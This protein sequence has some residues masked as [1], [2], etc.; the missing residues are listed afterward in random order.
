MGHCHHW[1]VV[2]G[3]VGGCW[4]WAI[5]EDGGWCL[6]FVRWGAGVGAGVG[7]SSLLVGGGGGWCSPF[8]WGHG[9]WCSP[10]VGGHGGWCSSFIGGHRHS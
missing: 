4:R 2:L 8:V 5:V 10:L 1:C 6:P 3:A 7:L 9:G